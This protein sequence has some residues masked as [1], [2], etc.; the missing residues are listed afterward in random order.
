MPY[1]LSWHIPNRVIAYQFYGNLTVDEII[2]S[3]HEYLE[4]LKCG[5]RVDT[6]VDLTELNRF[7]NNL[8]DAA[9]VLQH[10]FDEIRGWV[11]VVQKANPMLQYMVAM[12]A[13][14]MLKRARLRIESDVPSAIRFLT[15]QNVKFDAAVLT[16]PQP[17]EEGLF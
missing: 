1:Q 5:T 3:A 9:K 12:G 11:L 8:S 7:P 15:E 16:F 6:L 14:M 13:Q 10:R 17:V 2:E 4:M